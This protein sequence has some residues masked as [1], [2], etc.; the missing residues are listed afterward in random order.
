MIR[1]T[2]ELAVRVLEEIIDYQNIPEAGEKS[3]RQ[4]V[5]GIG[6]IGLAHIRKTWC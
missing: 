3:Q 5:P 1:R 4:D 6:Y 2:C